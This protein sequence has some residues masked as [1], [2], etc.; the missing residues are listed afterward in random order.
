MIALQW[1]ITGRFVSPLQF[2]LDV[3]RD[4]GYHLAASL[5]DRNLW[6]I[7][8]WLLP[9][10]IPNLKR[11]PRSWLIP[12]GATCVMVLALDAYFGGPRQ[13][14][15]ERFS[16][17]PVRCSAC[18]RRY[19]CCGFPACFKNFEIRR[20]EEDGGKRG[21]STLPP[22]PAPGACSTAARGCSIAELPTRLLP[23]P[24]ALAH[25][26][27]HARRKAGAHAGVFFSPAIPTSVSVVPEFS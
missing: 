16:A 17:S 18:R 19:S 13:P 14:W 4:G 1:S 9:T 8:L 22:T 23:S 25:L 21:D 20:P 11:L 10:A 6:Y 15:A 24:P 5:H 7:F 12:V 3:H 2:G 27:G 26:P